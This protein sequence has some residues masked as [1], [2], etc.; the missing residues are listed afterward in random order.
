MKNILL[1]IH[2]LSLFQ[3]THLYNKFPPSTSYEA[4]VGEINLEDES[5][6]NVPWTDASNDVNV[7]WTDVRNNI[8]SERNVARDS[9]SVS[10][11]ISAPEFQIRAA[12]YDFWE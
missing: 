11:T 10:T 8:L 3:I 5:D 7:P 12:F 9:P 2:T 1:K 6:A 4:Y